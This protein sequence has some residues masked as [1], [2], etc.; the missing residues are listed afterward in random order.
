MDSPLA[1]E[2]DAAVN[3]VSTRGS[4]S[5]SMPSGRRRAYRSPSCRGS[6]PGHEVVDAPHRRDSCRVHLHLLG[7]HYPVEQPRSARTVDGS[8]HRRRDDLESDR[9]LGNLPLPCHPKEAND[10]DLRSADFETGRRDRHDERRP[11][12][13]RVSCVK[14]SPRRSSPLF[15]FRSPQP[16][17]MTRRERTRWTT[18]RQTQVVRGQSRRPGQLKEMSATSPAAPR[19]QP[20]M[21][22]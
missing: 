2:M 13:R 20:V 11:E 5:R 21:T 3:E 15:A 19:S 12:E 6:V 14:P 10:G 22:R 16:A 17:V 1:V 18:P 4:T 7:R 8:R 9:V